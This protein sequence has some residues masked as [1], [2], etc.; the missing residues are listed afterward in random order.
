MVSP[1]RYVYGS[2]ISTASTSSSALMYLASRSIG[3]A[4]QMEQYLGIAIALINNLKNKIQKSTLRNE[5]EI[6][7]C[8]KKYC[9]FVLRSRKY[10]YIHPLPTSNFMVQ[11]LISSAQ[12]T[13]YF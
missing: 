3:L 13:F 1:F 6:E 12:K 7:D 8:E 10:G 4:I 11:C 2:C 9:T 5:T